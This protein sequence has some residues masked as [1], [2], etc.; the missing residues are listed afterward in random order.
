[1]LSL[2]LVYGICACADF[3][4]HRAFASFFFTDAY[5]QNPGNDAGEG[6]VMAEAS[7]ASAAAAAAAAAARASSALT[8]ATQGRVL[9]DFVESGMRGEN[10]GRGLTSVHMAKKCIEEV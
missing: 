10:G 7:A 1:M 4:E 2:H 9:Q 3:V 5:F 6:A 8:S